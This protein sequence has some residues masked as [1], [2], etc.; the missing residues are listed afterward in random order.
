MDQAEGACLAPNRFCTRQW[1]PTYRHYGY[2]CSY[3]DHND[4]YRLR[5]LARG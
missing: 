4:R 2:T 5:R 1:Q 3:L